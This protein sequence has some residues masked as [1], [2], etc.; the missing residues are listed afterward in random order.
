MQRA[1]RDGRKER[2]AMERTVPTFTNNIDAEF[3]S[4]N[5]FRWAL[6]KEDGIELDKMF[7][8]EKRHFLDDFYAM[9]VGPFESVIMSKA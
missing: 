5:T 6:R 1:A 4:W 9:H 3:A 8:E 7:T 2:L